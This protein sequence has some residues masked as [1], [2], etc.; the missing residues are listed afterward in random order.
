MISLGEQVGIGACLSSWNSVFSKFIVVAPGTSM[1]A[2]STHL[3][4]SLCM[5]V[6]RVLG[7]WSRSEEGGLYSIFRSQDGHWQ[8]HEMQVL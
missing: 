3:S 1:L 5:G 4:I 6:G 7:A 2:L 8:E